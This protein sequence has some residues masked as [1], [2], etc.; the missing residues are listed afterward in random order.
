MNTQQQFVKNITRPFMA[1][2]KACEDGK[3]YK[4]PEHV[5]K[6]I[7]ILN[8]WYERKA[9]NKTKTLTPM[10]EKELQQ[11]SYF[12]PSK[13]Y[14]DLFQNVCIYR[15]FLSAC[16]NVHIEVAMWL[17]ENWPEIDHRVKDD[18][19]FCMAC[20]NGHLPVAKWLLETF[21]DIDNSA[22]K[23]YVF[24]LAHFTNKI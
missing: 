11:V 3:D 17:N 24:R 8:K 2:I 21:P 14:M 23:D 10:N 9:G 19:A 15:A 16:E 6:K 22:D 18:Y 4:Y 13:G 7:G 12:Y 1:T 20:E 5:E